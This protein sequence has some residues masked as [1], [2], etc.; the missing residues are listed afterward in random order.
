[1]VLVAPSI[2]HDSK[3]SMFGGFQENLK[4]FIHSK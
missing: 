2:H 1:M 4:L 3:N